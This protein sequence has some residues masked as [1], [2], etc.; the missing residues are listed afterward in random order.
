MSTPQLVAFGLLALSMLAYR[1]TRPAVALVASAV[2]VGFLVGLLNLAGAAA[3]LAMSLAGVGAVRV[4]PGRTRLACVI[5]LGV[6]AFVLA[7]HKIPGFANPFLAEQVLV[8]AVTE[9]YTLR[10]NFDKGAVG[11]ILLIMLGA[12]SSRRNARWGLR[13]ATAVAALS[14]LGVVA[15]AAATGF[16]AWDAQVKPLLPIFLVCNLFLTV[17]PE[18]AFFQALINRE[19]GSRLPGVAAVG[20]TALLFSAVH[21]GGGLAYAGLALLSGLVSAALW[22]L[23]KRIEPCIIAHFLINAMHFTLFTYPRA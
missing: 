6:L 8:G 3:L 22:Q 2:V 12:I 9:P 4:A 1:W 16:I 7:T 19:I 17:I 23:S 11:A 13:L 5:A 15:V 21:L 14:A 20:I 10:A 18:E